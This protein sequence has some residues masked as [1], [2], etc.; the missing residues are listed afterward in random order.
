MIK[1]VSSQ[2]SAVSLKKKRADGILAIPIDPQSS[3]KA[4]DDG[5]GTFSTQQ[6]PK[7]QYMSPSSDSEIND[8]DPPSRETEQLSRPDY[9][10]NKRRPKNS[11]SLSLSLSIPSPLQSAE[12]VPKEPAEYEIL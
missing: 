10:Q 11:L 9:Y 7:F 6:A 1:A 12:G 5:P 8:S 2:R 4:G 3:S